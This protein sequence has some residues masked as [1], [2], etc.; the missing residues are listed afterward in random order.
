MLYTVRINVML[1]IMMKNVISYDE[2]NCDVDNRQNYNSRPQK[3][4]TKWQSKWQLDEKS[5]VFLLDTLQVIMNSKQNELCG[6]I[7]VQYQE[8]LI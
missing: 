2:V 8:R 6:M 7:N 3:R 5:R 4:G 1:Y